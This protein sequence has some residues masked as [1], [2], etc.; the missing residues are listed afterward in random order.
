MLAF[1]RVRRCLCLSPLR[2]GAGVLLR[3]LLLRRLLLLAPVRWRWPRARRRSPRSAAALVARAL[4]GADPARLLFGVVWCGSGVVVD[5]DNDLPHPADWA[6][7]SG[8]RNSEVRLG[9]AS[10]R[11]D[12]QHVLLTSCPRL[13]TNRSVFKERTSTQSSLMS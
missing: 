13:T 8:T 2:A 4:T 10:H 6:S 5:N 9:S 3:L 1:A 11:D 12:R 7:S